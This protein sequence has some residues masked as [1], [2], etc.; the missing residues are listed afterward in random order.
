MRFVLQRLS[1]YLG[2]ALA[3][4]L[5]GL[6]IGAVRAS[7]SEP[8]QAPPL[9]NIAAPLNTG[10]LS[11]SKAGGL[12]L[13][14][15]G[16]PGSLVS[17]T[18]IGIGSAVRATYK[19]MGADG[20][21]AALFECGGGL[22]I[23][24]AGTARFPSALIL[25]GNS[26]TPNARTTNQAKAFWVSMPPY[27][28]AQRFV[29]VI[30]GDIVSGSNVIDIGGGNSNLNAATVIKFFTG[31]TQNVAGGTEAVRIT[32]PRLGQTIGDLQVNNQIR[33]I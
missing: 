13:G 3:S 30:G 33:I 22:D 20:C 9:G 2:V 8:V 19:N 21:R 26:A 11:Q 16:P 1:I 28:M 4:T 29:S 17:I 14:T 18:G 23:V 27:N 24:W 12:V 5:L 31:A 25:G 6:T 7:W 10:P 32:P 15:G